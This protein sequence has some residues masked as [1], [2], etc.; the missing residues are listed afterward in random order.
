MPLRP[1]DTDAEARLRRTGGQVV[2]AVSPG[3]MSETRSGSRRPH[4]IDDRQHGKWTEPDR[5]RTA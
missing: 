5:T 3:S 1:L 4:A 2:S